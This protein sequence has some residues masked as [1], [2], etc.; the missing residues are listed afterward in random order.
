MNGQFHGLDHENLKVFGH[1]IRNMD[2]MKQITSE[3]YKKYKIRTTNLND[4]LKSVC[5]T[6]KL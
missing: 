6:I 2:F 4:E 5:N 3:A 1:G